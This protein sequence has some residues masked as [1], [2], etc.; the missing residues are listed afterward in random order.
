MK[1]ILFLTP[2]LPYPPISGGTIKTYKMLEFLA[3]KYEI[4]LAC[5]LKNDDEKKLKEYQ[6]HSGIKNII[7]EPLQVER[8]AMNLIRSNVKLIP[9]NLLRNQSAAFREKLRNVWEQ[10]DII[11][12]DHYVMYQY[13]PSTIKAKV[14]LHQHN[15]EYLIW[16]RYAAIEKNIL[17]KAALLNQSW[18]I[19][20]YEK[21][22]CRQADIILAAPNDTD[23]LVAIGADRSRFYPTY[24]LGDDSLLSQ[25]DLHFP[26]SEKSIL[27]V[28]TLS[29]EANINGLIWFFTHTWQD[30]SKKDPELKFYIVGKN[31][32]ARLLEFAQKDPRIIFT[33]FIADL[34]PFFRR[35]RVFVS[36]LLFGS[37]IKVKVISSMYRGI[38]CVTTSVGAEGL[39]LTDGKEIFIRNDEKSFGEAIS[40][41]LENPG[42]W[43]SVSTAARQMA[44]E[45]LSWGSVFQNLEHAIEAV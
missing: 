40:L 15:C 24:H 45:K 30:I 9:L 16:Q 28:G 36:P 23:E 29:W 27:Y 12:V 18:H 31:P 44:R 11:L 32:D 2:Q 39:N 3:G 25:P 41:L 17:K 38:P 10:H 33:G 26:D 13:V 6:L 19:K 34:E 35:S 42:K 7:S 1:K 4:T 20:R 37:G 21:K 14:I 43:Q 5:L 22:I 8:N